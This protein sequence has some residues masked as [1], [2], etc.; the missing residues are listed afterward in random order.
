MLNGKNKQN[1]SA[2]AACKKSSLTLPPNEITIDMIA[3]VKK[4]PMHRLARLARIAGTARDNFVNLGMGSHA[5]NGSGDGDPV[6]GGSRWSTLMQGRSP[7]TGSAA[8]ST[9]EGENGTWI[10]SRPPLGPRTSNTSDDSSI[11]TMSN[12]AGIARDQNFK[13]FFA[14]LT[15]TI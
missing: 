13:T 14:N 5:S 4:S 7:G 1:I 11:A 9:E 2:I 12:E 10:P 15:A 8:G 3:Q 6:Q